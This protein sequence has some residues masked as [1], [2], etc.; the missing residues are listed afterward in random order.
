M[1]IGLVV[2]TYR[3]RIAELMLSEALHTAREHSLNVVEVIKVPGAYDAPL[4]VKK[5]LK[6]KDVHAVAVLGAVVKG[7]T[8]HDELVAFTAANAFTALGL[9][10]EKPVA[11]GLIGPGA[12]LR[13]AHA[14]A[15]KYARHAVQTCKAQLEWLVHHSGP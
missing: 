4:A 7:G 10:F 3:K 1:N 13:Q 9:K 2:A 5:L 8:K 14:R 15:K 12:S 6:R 11:C